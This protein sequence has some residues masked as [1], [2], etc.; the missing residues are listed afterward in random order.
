MYEG[1]IIKEL[2]LKQN[3]SQTELS[4]AVTGR[5]NSSLHYLAKN[6]T[7]KTL[8]K[9]ADFFCVSIDTF[10]VNRACPHVD[11]ET[12]KDAEN[13]YLKKLIK[14]Q[15]TEMSTYKLLHDTND[16]LVE[17]LK[18]RVAELESRLKYIEAHPEAM[19][20]LKP[21][22][23]FELIVPAAKI[24]PDVKVYTN[25][26]PEEKKQMRIKKKLEKQAEEN[27]RKGTLPD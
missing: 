4:K 11:Y 2:L 13:G 23:R 17:Q 22:P 26:T 3:K 24:H 16:Y 1:R 19:G 25:P 8:E 9:I 10:F 14:Y 21:L 15:E 5:P 7:A 20:E 12:E 18:H 27:I 6:P